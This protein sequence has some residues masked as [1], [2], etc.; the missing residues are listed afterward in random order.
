MTEATP[1]CCPP[2]TRR[3][4][5]LFPEAGHVIAAALDHDSLLCEKHLKILFEQLLLQPFRCVPRPSTSSINV[6]LIIDALDECETP[7]RSGW[8]QRSPR[9]HPAILR[10]LDLLVYQ[11]VL[12]S[13]FL[14]KLY[15]QQG[16]H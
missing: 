7:L 2:V 9:M 11:L 1:S 13:H 5:D 10:D 15:V 12:Q 6:V 14:N 3:F 8:L 4:A 16:Q